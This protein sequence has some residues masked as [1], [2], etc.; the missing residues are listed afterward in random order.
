MFIVCLAVNYFVIFSLSPSDILGPCAHAKAIVWKIAFAPCFFLKLVESCKKYAIDT[1]L[2]FFHFYHFSGELLNCYRCA[3]TLL[4]IL[5][6]NCSFL[7]DCG[8]CE[9]RSLWMS[10]GYM[11]WFHVCRIME[12]VFFHPHWEVHCCCW[13]KIF[14]DFFKLN[15]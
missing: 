3:F 12:P 10:H 9:S 13:C 15:A 6:R 8:G 11:M 1:Y 5:W 14:L 4:T 7:A 2:W